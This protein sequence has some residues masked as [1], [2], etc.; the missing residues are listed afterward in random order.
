L[1]RQIVRVHSIRAGDTALDLE[2]LDTIN[3]IGR[4]T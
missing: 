2:G 3:S 4:R 1:V